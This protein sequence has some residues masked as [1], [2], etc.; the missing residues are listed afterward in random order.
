MRFL[1]KIR[2]RQFAKKWGGAYNL[3]RAVLAGVLAA[4][5]LMPRFAEAAELHDSSG[6][7][8]HPVGNIA[9]ITGDISGAGDREIYWKPDDVGASVEGY[10]INVN[11]VNSTNISINIYG[12]YSIH[13][14]ANENSVIISN[15]EFNNVR[16]GFS[17]ANTA[18]KNS[19]IINGGT[20]NG[21]VQGGNGLNAYGNSVI[22]S[23]GEFNATVSG[24][25]GGNAADG[26]SVSIGG[27]TF[28]GVVSVDM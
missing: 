24:G 7:N 2:E 11:N 23:D 28:N 13:G 5:C 22:I 27:G 3:S 14:T 4:G 15:G 19:V 25:D 9:T 16:G 10:K 21:S 1:S 20:F 18:N 12:G 6:V 8:W 26:N 17:D